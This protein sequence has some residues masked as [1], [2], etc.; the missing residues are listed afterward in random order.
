MIRL[1]RDL[2]VRRNLLVARSAAQR[3]AIRELLRP[4]ALR[5]AAAESVIAGLSRVVLL[6]V[7]LAPLY[8]ML[9]RP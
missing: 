9:R 6:A 1:M 4:A 5:M 2:S 7:R 8:S 3:G